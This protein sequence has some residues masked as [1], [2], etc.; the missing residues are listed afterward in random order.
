[1]NK[2]YTRLLICRHCGI[3]MGSI[4]IRLKALYIDDV[5]CQK[6]ESVED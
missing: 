5:V 3:N 6:C 1:M 4:T 2:E